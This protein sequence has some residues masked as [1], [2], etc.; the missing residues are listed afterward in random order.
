MMNEEKNR[1]STEIFAI[2][3]SP[4]SAHAISFEGKI[5]PTCEHAYQ[6]SRY[7][8]QSIQEEIR[9]AMSPKLAWELSQKYKHLQNPDFNEKRVEVMK[10][11]CR[12]KIQQQ[13]DVRN[14][15]AESKK[16]SIVKH[17]TTGPPGDGFWC[18][19]VRGEGENHYGKIWIKLREEMLLQ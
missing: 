7:E 1:V 19:G 17:I 12:L 4:Y 5:Y 15:L 8:D 3:F 18:D 9:T 14:A 11:F 10:N 13:E 6:A 2:Y 16:L